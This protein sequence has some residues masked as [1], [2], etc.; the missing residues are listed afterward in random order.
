MKACFQFSVKCSLWVITFLFKIIQIKGSKCKYPNIY[1]SYSLKIPHRKQMHNVSKLWSLR[2]RQQIFLFNENNPNLNPNI[3][4][5]H[6][7]INWG[8]T[9]QSGQQWTV[10]SFR[11]QVYPWSS[12]LLKL[13]NCCGNDDDDDRPSLCHC[14]LPFYIK[15]HSESASKSFIDDE[16][17]NTL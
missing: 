4:P 8:G 3:S 12:R 2:K 9:L 6:Q 10:R 1:I 15:Q 16:L 5:Q 13:P 17:G 7:P 14:L 11:K